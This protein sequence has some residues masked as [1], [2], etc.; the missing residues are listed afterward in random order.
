MR[1]LQISFDPPSLVP[2]CGR[3]V[4]CTQN[5]AALT[6][7][8]HEVHLLTGRTATAAPAAIP[9]A[10]TVHSADI[11]VRRKSRREKRLAL[12][13]NEAAF[14]LYTPIAQGFQ[15]AVD[16]VV[17][18]IRPELVW[19][20]EKV[21]VPDGLPVVYSHHDFLHKI[22]PL[23]EGLTR[24]GVRW[25]D[26]IRHARFRRAE[27]NRCERADH[28]VFASASEMEDLGRL[29]R[30]ATYIPVVGTTIARRADSTASRG[31]VFV[32]GHEKATAM[33]V[34]LRHLRDCVWPL[35]GEDG[36]GLDAEWHQV[37]SPPPGEGSD[38]W[39]WLAERF[40]CNGFVEDLSTVFRLGDACL[41]S[42]PKESGFR[43]KFV[44]A[45]AHG[46]VNIGYRHGFH[47]A[48]EFTPE[49][50]CLVGDTPEELV[51]QLRRWAG[52]VALRRRLGEAARALYE[53]EF[54]FEAQLPRYERVL[55]RVRAAR[56][57]Q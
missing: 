26:R 30:R 55:R 28:L 3:E 21:S 36:E 46:L 25:R 22:I 17:R 54:T 5:I 50:D 34:A 9:F 29:A 18:D 40:V 52:D 13:S 11:P 53:S 57:A 12:F 15:D 7:L 6:A 8:G 2:R 32:F 47:C 37:G 51:D 1:I 56:E 43:V 19:D 27:L 23:R 24:G 45:A 20:E 14:R 41:V 44:M 39:R 10:K 49:V 35:L 33:R 48:P 42:Y 38:A 16:A 31:R 4:R